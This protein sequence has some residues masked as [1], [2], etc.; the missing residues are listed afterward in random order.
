MSNRVI[1][2]LPKGT[3]IIKAPHDDNVIVGREAEEMLVEGKVRVIVVG[4]VGT[5]SQDTEDLA[6]QVAIARNEL[7]AG[8]VSGYGETTLVYE[9]PKGYFIGRT[10]NIAKTYYYDIVSEKIIELYKKGV[11]PSLLI[12]HS[13]GSMDIANAL[14]KLHSEGDKELYEGV[15]VKTFGCGVFFPEGLG[16]LEQYMGSL[17]TLG[18]SNTVNYNNIYWVWGRCHTT[19]PLYFCLNMPIEWYV[20]S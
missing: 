17:D 20:A 19:N 11:T 9:G 16:N 1:N 2:R 7:V 14:F 18:I 3:V 13:K 12:G 6:K 15:C 8:I 5:D 10:F 4:G